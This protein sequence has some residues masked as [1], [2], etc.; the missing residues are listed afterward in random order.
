MID[1]SVIAAIGLGA[2]IAWSG[3]MG[4]LSPPAIIMTETGQLIG[5]NQYRVGAFVVAM[6]QLLLVAVILL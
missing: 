1:W 5:S 6:I 3:L 4:V 2:Y